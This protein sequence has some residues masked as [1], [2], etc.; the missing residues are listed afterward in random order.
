MTAKGGNM[1]QN[2][3][4]FDHIHDFFAAN[5]GT[6]GHTASHT[7]GTEYHIGN[8]PKLLEGK[9]ASC[10]PKTGL[11][12]VQYEYG[13]CFIATLSDSLHVRV[14]RYLHA[15]FSLDTF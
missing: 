10:P 5:K 14:I 4:A 2:G 13:A 9:Q 15:S 1:P 12:L 11:N 3:I 8:N 7:F 6:D